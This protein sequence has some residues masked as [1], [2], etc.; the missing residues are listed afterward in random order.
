[1]T[2]QVCNQLER[3]N[4]S[5]LKTQTYLKHG[6]TYGDAARIYPRGSSM[7]SKRRK[8]PHRVDESGWF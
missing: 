4:G 8:F 1:M 5:K 6:S 2:T 7:R 3:R